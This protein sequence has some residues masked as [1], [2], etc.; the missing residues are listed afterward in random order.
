MKKPITIN[1][2]L[3]Y[4]NKFY[5]STR[6]WDS[7][8]DLEKL[9]E[10]FQNLGYSLAEYS[11]YEVSRNLNSFANQ[12]V[13][14]QSSEDREGYY[15]SYIEDV[16]LALKLS[17]AIL[18][19]DFP[20]LRAHHN[21]CF[22]EL[23][24]AHINNPILNNLDSHC[25]GTYED[26]YKNM[27]SFKNKW[28]IKPASGA[29]SKGVR[30][31]SNDIEKMSIPKIISTSFNF[32][33]YLKIKLKHLLRSRYKSYSKKSYHRNKFILQEFIEGLSG[34][35]KV[36]I[37]GEKYFIIERSNRKNDFRASGGGKLNL[38]PSL[39]E[40]LLDYCK[41]VFEIFNVPF[42][43]LDIALKDNLFFVIEFQ[44]LHFGNYTLEKSN[45]HYTYENDWVF[46]NGNVVLES[47]F[48]KSIDLH[49]KKNNIVIN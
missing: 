43:S 28:V 18:I 23:F 42:I 8:F 21:K 48:V 6:Y 46:N 5:S 36:L 22:M 45:H 15:K 40:G 10:Y 7:S 25:F 11:F 26:Y 29:L 24:K 12:I 14:Y 17:G 9:K 49:L 44:F 30:L 35:Y 39:P 16:I 33:E 19:P 13:I 20:M 37:Y 38:N 41:Y 3:D 4:R 47:E 2:I 27:K 1:L 32:K 34:D 31:A